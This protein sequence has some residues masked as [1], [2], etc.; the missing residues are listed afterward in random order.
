MRRLRA[1]SVSAVAAITLG[2]HAAVAEADAVGAPTLPA[3]WAARPAALPAPAVDVAAR[4]DERASDSATA[5]PGEPPA[6][7]RS[8]DT[9]F[10]AR[11]SYA[12][13]AAETL[14][15]A[16][17]LNQVN[18]HTD[19]SGTDFDSNASTIR[20]NLHSSWVVDRDPF[21]VNQLGHPYQGSMYHAF[22]RSAG[23]DYWKSLG[24]AFAVLTGVGLGLWLLIGLLSLRPTG[25]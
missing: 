23:L 24:Y 25:G 15:F 20:R 6:P 4:D 14:G 3:A 19:G 12:I 7:T 11:K 22:A 1:T 17:L 9:G 8:E 13:P 2:L 16:F 5:L 10:G 21:E 18:R